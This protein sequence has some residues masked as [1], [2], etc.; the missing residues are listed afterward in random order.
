MSYG[1]LALCGAFVPAVGL[2]MVT[3]S[4]V[5]LTLLL[6]T[7]FVAFF[8]G[9]LARADGGDVATRRR[10]TSAMVI[11]GVQLGLILLVS[12][13]LPSMGR[14]RE[15]ANRV[16]CGNNLTQIGRAMILYAN[17]N[18][19]AFPPSFAELIETQD[20]TSEVFVCPSS[21]AEKATGAT[22]QQVANFKANPSLHCSYIYAAAGMTNRVSATHVL[23]YEPLTNHDNRGINVL[24]GD[25]HTEWLDAAEAKWFIAELA[26]GRN[27]PRAM[28]GKAA[29][30]GTAA[31]STSPAK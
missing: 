3:G 25:G 6:L 11:A 23:A 26:A 28:P 1:A 2:L 19:G 20:I 8:S 16:K 13:L 24:Y 27:P 21:N 22:T 15:P 12:C 4:M 9:L 14:A 7:P 10:G 31:T 30:P 18:T 17:E 5:A 29:T